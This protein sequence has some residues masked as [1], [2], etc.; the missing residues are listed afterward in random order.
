MKVL[1]QGPGSSSGERK[2]AQLSM[3]VPASPQAGTALRRAMRS[4][5]VF[6]GP[7]KA[8]EVELLVTELATNGVK[9]GSMGGANRITLDAI[10]D[11]DGLHVSVS[12][13]GKG[14][15]PAPRE[16][17]RA[18]P[19]GWGLMLVEGI[20]DRWGVERGPTKVWF[21]LAGHHERLAA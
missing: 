4:F 8:D 7:G 6:L 20:A 5:E 3:S 19:G 11:D 14:F 21:E 16:P 10:L 1:G 12:D 15:T 18:E 2:R 13:R 9:H 17:D